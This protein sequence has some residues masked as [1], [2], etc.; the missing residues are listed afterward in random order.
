MVAEAEDWACALRAFDPASCALGRIGD[1]HDLAR[2]C[3]AFL[4]SSLLWQAVMDS[5]EARN[6]AELERLQGQRRRMR[7]GAA[8]GGYSARMTLLAAA[9]M[10]RGGAGAAQGV[11]RGRRERKRESQRQQKRERQRERKRLRRVQG[12]LTL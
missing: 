2:S 7:A 12:T 1:A 10:A 6:V 9:R 5:G 3:A 8:G 4:L 11:A